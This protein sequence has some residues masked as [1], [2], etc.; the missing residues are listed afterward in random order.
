[1]SDSKY[2]IRV[3]PHI[4]QFAEGV[5]VWYDEAALPGGVECNLIAAEQALEKYGESL[6]ARASSAGS[7]MESYRS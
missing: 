3:A 6:Q 7:D 1:M 4:D 2:P 5:F